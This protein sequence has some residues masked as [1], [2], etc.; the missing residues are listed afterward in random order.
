VVHHDAF[1]RREQIF[2]D[3]EISPDDFG[4]YLCSKLGLQV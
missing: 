3:I 2:T 4:E 1:A